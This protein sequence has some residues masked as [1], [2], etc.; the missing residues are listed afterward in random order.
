MSERLVEQSETWSEAKVNAESRVIEN[1]PLLGRFS[2]NGYEY[3]ESAMKDAVPLYEGVHVFMD[4]LPKGGTRSIRDLAGVV[5]K[6]RLTEGP[7]RGDVRT[8]DTDAGRTLLALATANVRKLG[9][10]H[11]ANGTKSKNGKV[12]ER[13]DAV[14]SVDA[15]LNPATTS[16]FSEQESVMDLKSL[17]ESHP[18]LVKQIEESAANAALELAEEAKK[19]DDAKM[20]KLRAT[21]NAEMAEAVKVA[22]VE[23]IK[24]EAKRQSDI[25]ALCETA[26]LPDLADTLC[27]EQTVDIEEARRRLFD[28]LVKRHPAPT[29]G[30]G[31]K[32]LEEGKDE[33]AEYRKEFAEGNLAVM[34]NLTEA[35]YVNSRR[36]DD[37][38]PPLTEQK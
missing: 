8:L 9:M 10:S 16:S 29:A 13:I 34:L 21:H 32:P 17:R 22:K 31:K 23:A 30:G 6:P 33:N 3:A 15:V 2:K 11:V 35:E 26:K 27:Q 7:I 20:A 18:D 24:E 28:E 19:T 12:V 36:K 38:K 5:E 37:G 4:H 14:A 25:R 1:V